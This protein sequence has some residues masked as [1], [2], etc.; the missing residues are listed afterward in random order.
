M[1]T[2]NTFNTDCLINARLIQICLGPHQVILNFEENI[3]ISITCEFTV[4]TKN[5]GAYTLKYEHGV[6]FLHADKLSECIDQKILEARFLYNSTHDIEL[7]FSNDS[8]ITIHK[9]SLTES[10]EIQMTSG[11]FT[12]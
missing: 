6:G 4:S 7:S 2:L 9:S 8:K 11:V 12:V 10:F 5:N 3:Q 1:K